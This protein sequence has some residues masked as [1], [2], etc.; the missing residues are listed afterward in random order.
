MMNK[1]HDACTAVIEYCPN[2]YAKA[3]A[4]AGLSMTD[5]HE[6]HVQALYILN[7]I[8]HWRGAIAK[9]TRANLKGV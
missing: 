2:G 3:Y 4:K 5:P 7:N 6:C 1:F 9:A 8:R